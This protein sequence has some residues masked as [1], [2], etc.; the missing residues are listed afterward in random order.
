MKYT[1]SNRFIFDLFTFIFLS[2]CSVQGYIVEGWILVLHTF[3][4]HVHNE[5]TQ[6]GLIVNGVTRAEWILH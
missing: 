5:K 4:N 1:F 3:E 6:Y 2:V